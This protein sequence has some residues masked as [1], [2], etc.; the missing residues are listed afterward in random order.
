MFM[1]FFFSNRFRLHFGYLYLLCISYS[2]LAVM[3]SAR[4]Y[5]QNLF[6]IKCY[7]LYNFS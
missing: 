6:E 7:C 3:L 2:S 1:I 4:K 5:F